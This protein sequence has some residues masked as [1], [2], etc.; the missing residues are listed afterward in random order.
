MGDTSTISHVYPFSISIVLP[1]LAFIPILPVSAVLPIF[2]NKAPISF[3]KPLP[4][5]LGLLDYNKHTSKFDFIC[6]QEENFLHYE[7]LKNYEF[8]IL[9]NNPRGEV[10]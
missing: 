7:S 1:F 8:E 6:V 10:V 5:F 3:L 2:E 9:D 4:Q